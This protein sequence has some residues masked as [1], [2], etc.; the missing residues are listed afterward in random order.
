MTNE[1]VRDDIMAQFYNLI[2]MPYK[3]ETTYYESNTNL[4]VISGWKLNARVVHTVTS[5]KS[6]FLPTP[7]SI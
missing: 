5:L 1:M 3:V 6:S 2:G 4:T 7:S